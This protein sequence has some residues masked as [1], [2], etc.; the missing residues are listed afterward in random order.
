ML[1]TPAVTVS[2]PVTDPDE[3]AEVAPWVAVITA[4]PTPLIVT[5]L[6]EMVATAWLPLA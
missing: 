5:T 4:V 2:M 6:P 3:N 1:G